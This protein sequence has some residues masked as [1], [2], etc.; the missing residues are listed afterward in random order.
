[1]D[2]RGPLMVE[3][4]NEAAADPLATVAEARRWLGAKLRA[5][6]SAT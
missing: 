3:M 5:G 4:W 1:M 6:F 2:F